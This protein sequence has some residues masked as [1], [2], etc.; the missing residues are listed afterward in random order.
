VIVVGPAALVSPNA[1]SVPMILTRRS[2]KRRKDNNFQNN[3]WLYG[4]DG[5]GVPSV[6][7]KRVAENAAA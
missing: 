5:D 7:P 2:F 4:Q 6:T 1:R 3:G